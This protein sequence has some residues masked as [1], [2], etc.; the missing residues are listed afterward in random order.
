MLES[1]RD[2]AIIQVK[3]NGFRVSVFEAKSE[4]TIFH[5]GHKDVD[6]S[7]PFIH[8]DNVR[9]DA[10]D[11]EDVVE[12]QANIDHGNGQRNHNNVEGQSVSDDEQARPLRCNL[13]SNSN[14]T[15]QEEQPR[16]EH[17]G[18]INSMS[19]MVENQEERANGLNAGSLV[20]ILGEPTLIV[21]EVATE[22]NA[23]QAE[24]RRLSI[25]DNSMSSST[26]TKTLMVSDNSY[27]VEMEKINWRRSDQLGKN[28][29]ANVEDEVDQAPPGFDVLIQPTGNTARVIKSTKRFTGTSEGR[30]VTRSQG[31]GLEME[32]NQ[33]EVCP[34]QIESDVST[35]PGFG[36]EKDPAP[37][38]YAGPAEMK[39]NLG[40]KG[41]EKKSHV[42]PG[43][44]IRVTRSQM[45]K[46]K[47]QAIESHS[48]VVRKRDAKN[49]VVDSSGD[50]QST[51]ESMKQIAEDALKIGELLGVKVISHRVNAVKR[52]TDSIKESRATS[53]VR[54]RS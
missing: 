10:M 6:S 26:K 31:A 8:K 34:A 33:K 49:H 43:A 27:S 36:T 25:G 11:S 48:T 19:V 20:R 4:F 30:R 46:N 17:E 40:R 16:K 2:E 15:H 51:T 21:N 39:V 54:I 3:N 28:Q 18:S 52:I 32:V 37:P 47:K 53:S 12:D 38:D 35:P 5:M 42:N 7:V 9:P 13:N 50:S 24:G 29:K 45:L 44:G 14:H 41:K 1:N 23:G 22:E